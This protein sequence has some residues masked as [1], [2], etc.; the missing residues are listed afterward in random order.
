[1]LADFLTLVLSSLYYDNAMS[2]YMALFF[3]SSIITRI[4]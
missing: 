2:H 1:M 4:R 3:L